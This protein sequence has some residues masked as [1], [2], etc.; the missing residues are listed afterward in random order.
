MTF[1]RLP[2]RST[3][4]NTGTRARTPGGRAASR[5]REPSE[6]ESARQRPGPGRDQAPPARASLSRLTG[7]TSD[8][9]II[10]RPP[11]ACQWVA[12]SAEPR[13][14][15]VTRPDSESGLSDS[16]GLPGP[17]DHH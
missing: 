6:P 17:S 4:R 8:S 2:A 15:T 9:M 7:V 14:R 11:R 13:S 12:R 16:E 3:T 1:D 10:L 5:R